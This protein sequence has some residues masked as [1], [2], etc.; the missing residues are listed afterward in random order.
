M[1][2]KYPQ[3]KVLHQVAFHPNDDLTNQLQNMYWEVTELKN[4]LTYTP[5]THASYQH[6]MAMLQGKQDVLQEI[7][8]NFNN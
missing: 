6:T 1:E 5:E 2:V 4:T 7:L 8:S 3:L